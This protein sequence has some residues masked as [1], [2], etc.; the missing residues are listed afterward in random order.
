MSL[1]TSNFHLPTDAQ[2]YFDSAETEQRMRKWSERHPLLSA[3]VKLEIQTGPTFL[4]NRQLE[5]LAHLVA[6]RFWYLVTIF[7]IGCEPSIG[8]ARRLDRATPSWR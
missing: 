7:G 4:H 6:I 3:G 2:P 1:A 5:E 8:R